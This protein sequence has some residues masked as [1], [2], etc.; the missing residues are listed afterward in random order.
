MEPS[1]RDVE[2]APGLV[3]PFSSAAALVGSPGQGAYA[4]ANSWLDAFTHWRRG[5]GLPATSIAWGAWAEIGRATELAESCGCR[6]R[7]GRGRPRVPGIAEP[8]RGYSGIPR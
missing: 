7:S 6:N 8:R 5:Q 2:P 1:H 4:A 3:L